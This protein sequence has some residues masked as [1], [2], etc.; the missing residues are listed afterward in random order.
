[1]KIAIDGPAGAGKSTIAKIVASKLGSIYIDTGAMYRAMAL[2]M[3]RNGIDPGDGETME[4]LCSNCR[5]SIAFLDGA[6]RVFLGDEDVTAYLRDEEVGKMASAVSKYPA[7]RTKL[8]ELQRELAE[9]CSVVMDG[10]DIGTVVL[11]DAELKIYLTADPHVRAVRRAK[12]LCGDREP[13]AQFVREIEDE[14][15][16]RDTND[17]T[18]EVSPLK[19]A[20][21]AVL[22]D[23]SYLSIDEVA[24][25]IIDHANRVLKETGDAV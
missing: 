4:K 22:V 14:I 24:G 25:L 18:R 19:K 11:P 3:I 23:S 17:M 9:K 16:L 12:E 13:D 21:D 10:R 6:Q 15:I 20:D 2:F 1:M 7:V 8:V 5:I